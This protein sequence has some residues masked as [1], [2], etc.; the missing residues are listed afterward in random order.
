MTLQYFKL[1]EFD[2]PDIPGSGT[3]MNLTF[4]HIMDRI[5]GR[6]GFPC[7]INSGYRTSER[8]MQEGGKKN[9]AHLRGKAADIDAPTSAQKYALVTAALLEGITR[10]GIGS[11]FIHLDNDETL[12]QNVIWTY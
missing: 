3:N 10:I 5:R 11:T 2:S 7:K 6:V 1:E 4:L 9:S 8:N 12:P